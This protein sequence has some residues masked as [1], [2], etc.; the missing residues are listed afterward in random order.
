ML[1]EFYDIYAFVGLEASAQELYA[2]P[3]VWIT[4]TWMNCKNITYS[5]TDS[6]THAFYGEP[7]S[8]S[9]TTLIIAL[10]CYCHCWSAKGE[11]RTALLR[12]RP[13]NLRFESLWIHWRR[14]KVIQIILR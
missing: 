11:T 6:S 10:H 2:L 4:C 8:D 3:L 13:Q 5:P 14:S 1:L 7:H 9:A 12:L